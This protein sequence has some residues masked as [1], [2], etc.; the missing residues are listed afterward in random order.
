MCTCH[1]TPRR[2]TEVND[3]TSYSGAPGFESQLEDPLSWLWESVIFL[4]PP[5]ACWNV[6]SKSV[7]T[8]SFH[9]L[10]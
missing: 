9:T 3:L 8:V 7:T 6:T 4:R 2:D 1:Q 10:Y 5:Q